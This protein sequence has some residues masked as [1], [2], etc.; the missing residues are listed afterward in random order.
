MAES[1]VKDIIRAVVQSI[2]PAGAGLPADTIFT[3][4]DAGSHAIKTEDGI[5]IIKEGT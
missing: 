5:I 3:E 2:I 4:G 1:V